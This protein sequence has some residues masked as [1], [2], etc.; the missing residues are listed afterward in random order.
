MITDL[1]DAAPGPE[2]EDAAFLRWL[3]S[4][5][6]TAAM[7][8][9]MQDTVDG[10]H[11]EVPAKLRALAVDGLQ[12]REREASVTRV[13]AALQ[14]LH[15]AMQLPPEAWESRWRHV[16]DL[17]ARAK[18]VTDLMLEVPEPQRTVLMQLMLPLQDT[19]A[20]L[21]RETR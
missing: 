13:G 20:K 10:K 17:H 3:S 6:G 7:Q 19:L 9:V 5:Q 16:R 15:E 8:T 12:Q 2:P 4:P 11:G 14:T 18:A 21:E 1:T